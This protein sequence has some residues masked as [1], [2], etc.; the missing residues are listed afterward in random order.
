MSGDERTQHRARDED[1]RAQSCDR[2]LQCVTPFGEYVSKYEYS[3]SVRSKYS[4]LKNWK[5]ESKL[6]KR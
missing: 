3:F 6:Q 1:G 5:E 2:W 4:A